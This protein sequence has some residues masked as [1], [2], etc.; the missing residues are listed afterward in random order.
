MA[1]AFDVKAIVKILFR[2]GSL[3]NLE[4]VGKA[5]ANLLS[6]WRP[7]NGYESLR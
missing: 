6:V 2:C 5:E 4:I 7:L 3:W 1:C